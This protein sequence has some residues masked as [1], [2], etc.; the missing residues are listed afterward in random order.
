MLKLAYKYKEQLHN[1]Y[2]DLLFDD[3]ERLNYFVTTN[4]FKYDLGIENES[5]NKLEFVS[6]DKNYN[7]IGFLRASI[8]RNI[9][10]VSNLS[11][12]NFYDKNLIFSRDLRKFLLD[13]FEKY[14]FNKINFTVV[15]GNPIEKMY[16]K[17]IKKYGGRIVGIYKNEVLL[18]DNKFYDLKVY[19]IMRKDYEKY[20]TNSNFLEKK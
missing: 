19:E 11:I 1:I 16:D 14:K 10:S 6:V 17:Y 4:W 9:Y 20:K 5:W 18:I 3:N 13:L 12:I 8:D 7:V 15:I 2:T